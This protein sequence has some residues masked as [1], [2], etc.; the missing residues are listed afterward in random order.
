MEVRHVLGFVIRRLLGVIEV[1]RDTAVR[2]MPGHGRSGVVGIPWRGVTSVEA[3]DRLLLGTGIGPAIA[4]DVR[5]RGEQIGMRDDE[6][7]RTCPA[8]RP[9]DDGP[10]RGVRRSAEL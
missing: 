1:S 6:G 3:V 9:A 7:D 8:R 2:A 4:P 10:V 5:E